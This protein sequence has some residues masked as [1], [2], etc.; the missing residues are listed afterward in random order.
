MNW[1]VS[2]VVVDSLD[3]FDSSNNGA[4]SGKEDNNVKN[5]SN[6]GKEGVEHEYNGNKATSN[7]EDEG[8]ESHANKDTKKGN[9]LLLKTEQSN[10]KS[11]NVQEEIEQVAH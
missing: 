4:D 11:N 2:L 5:T 1:K 8:E 9:V 7:R 10:D 6:E 3:E